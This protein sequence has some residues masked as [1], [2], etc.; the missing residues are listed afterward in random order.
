MFFFGLVTGT[1][2]V[3]LGGDVNLNHIKPVLPLCSQDPEA[4]EWEGM[5]SGHGRV[6]TM[7]LDF[8]RDG[9]FFVRIVPLVNHHFFTTN[10]GEYVFLLF[11]S[12]EDTNPS[13]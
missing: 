11:A 7:F 4:M 9:D 8:F 12:I 5:G 10:L 2:W 13:V 3:G 1:S 6:A